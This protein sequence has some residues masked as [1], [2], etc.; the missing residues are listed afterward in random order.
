MSG[1]PNGPPESMTAKENQT[2]NGDF[3]AFFSVLNL[4][5]PQILLRTAFLW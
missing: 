5:G 1:E 4:I 2:K 3:C